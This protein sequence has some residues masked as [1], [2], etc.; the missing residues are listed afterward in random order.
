MLFLQLSSCNLVRTW[1]VNLEQGIQ[2][3]Q[4][5]NKNVLILNSTT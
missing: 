3:K 5:D 2:L 4:I 1:E